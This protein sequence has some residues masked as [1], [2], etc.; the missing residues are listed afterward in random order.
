ME[1]VFVTRRLPQKGLLRITEKYDADV[2]PLQEPPTRDQIMDRGRDCEGLVTLL[3]DPIDAEVIAALPK[4]RVIAQ[5][6]VG[7]DNIDVSAATAAGIIVTNTPGV[8][9]ETTADLT[10]ALILAASR[11]V[12]EGDRYVRDGK[13]SVAWG[14]ELMLGEDVHGATLGI[15]GFGRI[16]QAVA[17]RAK[18]FG[19]RVLYHTRR[20]TK[21]QQKTA[22]EAG[23][24]AVTFDHLLKESDIVSLHVPLTEETRNMIDTDALNQM[25][26]GSIL[27]NTSRGAVLDENALYNALVS[28]HLF[29]AGLDVFETEPIPEESPLM[30]LPNVV[31]APHIGSAS[32]HTRN[33]MAEMC[34]D[35]LD[36]AL[37]GEKPPNIV[38]PEVL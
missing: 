19:M 21:E 25:K 33:V 37:H 7:Y 38:N 30:A 31:L 26:R 32:R 11:R 9:T 5:Y 12:A 17:R 22:E 36:A 15:V 1:K 8:L 3:S 16:G 13:W 24:R 29:A 20:D 34:A 6:A 28:G 4:L 35:N 10:W 14:P 2:W 23:A 27:V 18:G